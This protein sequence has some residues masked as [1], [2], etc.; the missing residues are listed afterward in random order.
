[1]LARSETSIRSIPS[2]T[3]SRLDLNFIGTSIVLAAIGCVAVYSATWFTGVPYWERQLVWSVVGIGLMVVF[4]TIDYHVYLDVSMIL[5][6]VGMVLLL[7]LLVY[8]RVTANVRSWIYF[9]G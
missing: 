4:I 5:Y 3:V 7:Y 2:R 6:G 1:M 9:A 8:G